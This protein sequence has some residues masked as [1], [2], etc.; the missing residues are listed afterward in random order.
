MEEHHFSLCGQLLLCH[1]LPYKVN[2]HPW[3]YDA[4]FIPASLR[5]QL[6]KVFRHLDPYLVPCGNHLIEVKQYTHL[7]GAEK[8]RTAISVWSK[9][10]T[11]A[12]TAHFKPEE[13]LLETLSNVEPSV[14]SDPEPEE[15][16]MKKKH[17]QVTGG[18]VGPRW[19]EVFYKGIKSKM[20]NLKD[21]DLFDVYNTRP[22]PIL[23]NATEYKPKFTVQNGIITA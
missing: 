11:L 20:C 1:D 13:E 10:V 8:I 4:A 14:I 9:Q 17:V 21:E 16:P 23:P 15:R 7:T 19:T 6:S 3:Y 12:T 22:L 2:F 18:I 5:H